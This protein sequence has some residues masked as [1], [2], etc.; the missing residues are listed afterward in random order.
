MGAGQAGFLSCQSFLLTPG[1]RNIPQAG[2]L[3]GC[4]KSLSSVEVLDLIEGACVTLTSF[5]SGLFV[6]VFN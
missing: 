4:T 5:G 1:Q 3:W 6:G 2:C